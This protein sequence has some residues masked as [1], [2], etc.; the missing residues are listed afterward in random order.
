MKQL[1]RIL[2]IFILSLLLYACEETA[3]STIDVLVPNGTTSF[4]HAQI[5]YENNDILIERVSGPNILISA[6]TSESHDIIIAPVNLGANLYNK[7]S[8]YQLLGVLTWN[9]LQFI[10]DEPIHT[11]D[12]LV[13]KDIQ[14]FGEGS[15]PEMIVETLLQKSDVATEVSMNYRAQSVQESY[16]HFKQNGGVALVAEPIT[17]MAKSNSDQLYVLD[18]AD[19]WSEYTE[20]ENFP[21]SGV[22]VKP[23]L[24]EDDTA[25]YLNALTENMETLTTDPAEIADYGQRLNYPFPQQIIEQSIPSSGIDFIPINSCKDEVDAFM[26][27]ILTF[28]GNL[29]NNEIPDDDFYYKKDE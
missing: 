14:A 16:T 1:Y 20:Y 10:S 2:I 11:I 22:F 25:I 4:S 8:D 28:N 15:I 3:D 9:N 6:F 24:S 17:T 27:L 29:I 12:D 5:E 19:L 18:L 13:G 23:S 7:G 21:Q 26:R